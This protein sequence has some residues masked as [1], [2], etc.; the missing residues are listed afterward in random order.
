MTHRHSILFRSI[1]HIIH[2][3][4]VATGAA[5]LYADKLE[6][7]P[8]LTPS[9]AAQLNADLE[10][11]CNVLSA[12][13][14]ALPQ[15]LATWQVLMMLPDEELAANV[16]ATVADAGGTLSTRVADKVVAIR[17]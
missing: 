13:S 2:I 4:Q 14:V 12:L 3:T 5:E 11:F 7:L 10:Y 1:I 6:Q 15:R 16:Q 8:K 9:G 17:C